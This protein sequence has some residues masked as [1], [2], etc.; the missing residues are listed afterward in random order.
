MKECKYT[1]W[2]SLSPL[3]E[4]QRCLLFYGEETYLKEQALRRCREELAGGAFAAFN[5][6]E[7]E[8]AEINS[9]QLSDAVESCPVMQPTKLVVLRDLDVLKPPSALKEVLT[10][11]L[12]GLPEFCYVI[13]Y[14][15]VLP[16]KPDKRSKQYAWLEQNVQRVCFDALDSGS[17]CRWVEEQLRERGCAIGREEQEYLL[18]LCGHSMTNLLTEMEKIAAYIQGRGRVTR[19]DLDAVCVK[20]MDAVLF[21]LTDQ[22]AARRYDGAVAVLRELLAQ[23]QDPIVILASVSSHLQKLYAVKLAKGKSEQ[24]KM[25]LLGTR[26]GYYVRKM[27]AAAQKVT[28]PWLRRA[29]LACAQY[30]LAL[31][32]SSADKGR[33]V[34]LLLLKLYALQEGKT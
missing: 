21:D 15:D 9:E 28:L 2:D 24:E 34:E 5:L 19:E 7:L 26:S 3:L 20:T 16:Y 10:D 25:A 8:G 4:S 18:F 6:I 23:R 1:G 11:L 29:L 17:L 27:Q 33:T 30:D 31:K 22:L 14:Y 13:L 32:S 12:S